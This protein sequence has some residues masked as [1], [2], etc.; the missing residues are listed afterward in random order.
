[1]SRATRSV[2]PP[3]AEVTMRT[4]R[5]GNSCACTAPQNAT[6][7]TDKIEIRQRNIAFFSVDDNS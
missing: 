7:L 2:A 4:G 3:T 6:V 1:M 5:V